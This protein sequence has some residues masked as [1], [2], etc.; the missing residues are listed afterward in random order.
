MLPPTKAFVALL[1]SATSLAAP[2]ED[3]LLSPTSTSTPE[4][5]TTTDPPSS[6]AVILFPGFAPL[7]VFG[8]LGPLEMVGFHRGATL[9]LVAATLDPVS[10]DVEKNSTFSQSVVP[11]LTFDQF[12]SD[13]TEVDVII[14]P[15]GGGVRVSD[16]DLAPVVN[17]VKEVYPRLQ[18]LITICTGAGIAAKAGVL[19]GKRAT[20]NKAAWDEITVMRPQVE[21]VSPA[22]WVVDG[23]IWSSSGVTSGL[24]LTAEFMRQMYG[25]DLT[26]HS[27]GVMEYTPHPQDYDPFAEMFGVPPSP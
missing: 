24:D 26:E 15:G 8:P 12:L 21:W 18:Y 23:N 17:F 16:E 22:R 6:Y 14:L 5:I 7:D 9:K 19:D 1:L 27:L 4:P 10:S 2:S 13:D 3:D 11:D 20:T 25:E